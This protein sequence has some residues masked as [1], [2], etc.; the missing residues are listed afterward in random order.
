MPVNFLDQ[1]DARF[2][3][4]HNICD[5]E[6]QSLHDDGIGTERKSANIEDENRLWDSGVLSTKIPD[7]LQ[8][9]VFYYLGK[10]CCLRGEEQRNLKLSQFTRLHN[11]ER[12]MYTEHGS[13]NRNGGFYQLHVENKLIVIVI[14]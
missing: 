6:L 5:S 12:Y 8:E 10:V 3:A 7:G 14:V 4:L 13:K 1:G 9:A 2:K 11:P